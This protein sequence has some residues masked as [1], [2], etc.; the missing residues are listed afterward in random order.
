MIRI[1]GKYAVWIPMNTLYSNSDDNDSLFPSVKQYRYLINIVSYQV[2]T[3]EAYVINAKINKTF[4]T[5]CCV[6]WKRWYFQ[7][8]THCIKAVLSDVGVILD[9]SSNSK[10]IMCSTFI[11]YS[12]Y[13][14][15]IS[16]IKKFRQIRSVTDCMEEGMLH[17]EQISKI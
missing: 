3:T 13:T 5:K 4:F 15:L 16:Y 10:L 8:H 7:M 17:K 9:K 6:K 14:Y 12:S 2:I 1:S 11:L